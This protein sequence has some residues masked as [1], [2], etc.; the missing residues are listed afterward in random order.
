MELSKLHTLGLIICLLTSSITIGQQRLSSISGQLNDRYDSP[1]PFVM[2]SLLSKSDNNLVKGGLTD[3]LGFFELAKV[4]TGQYIIA[5]NSINI[6]TTNI[7]E[8]LVKERGLDIV[9]GQ[10][11]LDIQAQNLPEIVVKSKK[12]LI[13][14]RIDRMIVNLAD[15]DLAVGN[16]V[17]EVLRYLP[18]IT[19]LPD[20][21]ISLYGSN[22]IAVY[23]DGKTQ[24]DP[25]EVSALL[26]GLTAENIEKI[27]VYSTPPAR[28]SAQSSSII[29][30]VTKKDKMISSVNTSIGQ[31]LYPVNTKFG[32]DYYNL[33]GGFDLHY[34]FDKFKLSWLTSMS[35]R[36]EFSL[37]DQQ[38]SLPNIHR[39]IS[40][41][42]LFK[43]STLISTLNA[44][45]LLNAQNEFFFHSKLFAMPT[46]NTLLEGQNT[47]TELQTQQKE[48]SQSTYKN[49]ANYLSPEFLINYTHYFNKQRTSMFS[50]DAIHYDYTRNNK[51]RQ[52]QGENDKLFDQENDAE[53]NVK[54]I[55]LDYGNKW[56]KTTLRA[57]SKFSD[58][59]YSAITQSE[60]FDDQFKFEEQVAAAYI[61]LSRRCKD[62][63]FKVG[64][65]GEN[66]T[67]TAISKEIPQQQ[68]TDD[69]FEFFPSLF[70]LY[71]AK[72]NLQFRFSYARRI[73]RPSFEHYNPL[74]LWSTYDPFTSTQGSP[75]LL[76]QFSNN[77][78]LGIFWKE[79]NYNL[80]YNI[81]S[82]VRTLVPGDSEEDVLN[83]VNINTNTHSFNN[84]LSHPF[85]ITSIWQSRNNFSLTYYSS[86]LVNEN[87]TS[88]A[89]SFNSLHTLKLKNQSKLELNAAYSS[90]YDY[91]Y[92][93]IGDRLAFD[94][95]FSTYLIKN[96]RV[97]LSINNLLGAKAA[98]W[99]SNY[100]NIREL[101]QYRSNDRIL[102]LNISYQFKT[103]NQFR[104]KQKQT[105]DGEIR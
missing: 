41:R 65:R 31:L 86:D 39:N 30:I 66:T 13:E 105:S 92:W 79:L 9:L 78:E 58:L 35:S 85:S 22:G 23:L 91:N 101:Q 53:L 80:R 45:Y 29:N 96:L 18:G 11:T 90:A 48:T 32:T 16:S 89:W 71:N 75:R 38:T 57:G 15:S 94:L 8:V 84:T 62:I 54:A 60:T 72:D 68:I 1:L 95:G 87:R 103:G 97:K 36:N 26:E 34:G 14:R 44:Q 6:P 104:T 50:V 28:F 51:T 73:N 76:P 99:N 74:Q 59:N 21:T 10:L 67:I 5:A 3:S 70:T 102:R 33:R 93:Q 77:I 63:A 69:Y 17:F 19:T 47:I 98:V 7:T 12:P 24:I 49:N 20:G 25:G 83:F 81:E 42:Q 56:K 43:T 46:L 82:N 4:D 27:I 64:L 100:G 37:L 52:L 61:S 55:R 88:W 2:I 40:N